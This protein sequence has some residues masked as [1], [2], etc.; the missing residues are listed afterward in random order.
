MNKERYETD[1]GLE[2]E[3]RWGINQST[4]CLLVVLIV[5][6]H[7]GGLWAAVGAGAF[8]WGVTQYVRGCLAIS[9]DALRPPQPK[10]DTPVRFHKPPVD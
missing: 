3:V 6:Y 10:T 8:Y 4:I 5:A 2:T 1:K 9:I 7:F